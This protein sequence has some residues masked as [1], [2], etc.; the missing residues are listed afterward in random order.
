MKKADLQEIIFVNTIVTEIKWKT[1][2]NWWDIHYER[3][4]TE[5]NNNNNNEVHAAL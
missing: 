4:Y 3:N 5:I 1:I 2:I